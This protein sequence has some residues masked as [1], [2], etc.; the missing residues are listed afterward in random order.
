MDCSPQ[1]VSVKEIYTPNPITVFP[2]EC[3]DDCMNLMLKKDF[4]HLPLVAKRGGD[5][6]HVVIG[7]ISIKDCVKTVMD[8]K[9]ETIQVLSNFA[10]GKTGTFICD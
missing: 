5:D 7:M 1:D 10:L 4:R 9:E 2:D 6:N 3:I 8:S